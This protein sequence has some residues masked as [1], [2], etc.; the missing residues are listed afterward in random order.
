MSDTPLREWITDGIGDHVTHS[1]RGP[2]AVDPLSNGKERAFVPSAPEAPRDAGNAAGVGPANRAGVVSAILLM[3]AGMI[4]LMAVITAEALFPAA[5]TTSHNT[6]SD[7]GSTWQPGNVV[8]EPSA[9]IFNATMV[10]TGLMIVGGGASFWRTHNSPPLAIALLL[11]GVGMFGVGLFP[12]TEI[13]GHFS[14]TG[15]HPPLSI[16]TFS[17]G[18]ACA[19]LAYRVTRSPFRYLSGMLGLVALLSLVASGPLGDTKLG[20]GGVERWVAYPILLWLVAF[21]GYVLGRNTPAQ[22]SAPAEHK[23]KTARRPPRRRR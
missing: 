20:L 13:N 6:L 2:R 18:A 5:Y 21:G 14:T 3:L 19:I 10:V 15:I 9:T 22:L 12:G 23:S 1:L 17:S 16:L 4:F 7:L 11:F 8:R